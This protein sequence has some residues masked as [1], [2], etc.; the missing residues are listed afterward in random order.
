M[1]HQLA[2]TWLR[3][4]SLDCDQS[5]Y[6]RQFCW[7]AATIAACCWIFELEHRRDGLHFIVYLAAF[8]CYFLRD[9]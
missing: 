3:S 2:M 9:P 6:H 5:R 4:Q 1:S 7:A 8:G